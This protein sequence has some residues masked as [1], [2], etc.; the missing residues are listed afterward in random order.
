MR[1]FDENNQGG[2][3]PL[4]GANY[5]YEDYPSYETYEPQ[6]MQMQ[7]DQ[8]PYD[9][10]TNTYYD[11]GYVEGNAGPNPPEEK[12]KKRKWLFWLIFL[13]ALCVFIYSAYQLFIILKANWDE[14]REMERI[15]EIANIPENPETPFEVNWAELRNIN[16]DVV[17]WLIVP[18]TNISYPVVRGSNNSYYLERTFEKA[19]NY[20]GS[21]FMDY[22]NKGDFSDNNTFLY[23]H[24]TRHGTMFGQLENFVEQ[25][26]FAS[27]KYIYLFTPTQNYKAEIISFH[28]TKD[29]SDFYKYGIED[30]AEWEK[31]ID[32][33]TAND[34][35]GYVHSDVEVGASDRIVSLS[36]CSYEINNEL[37]DQRY[38]LH[39]KL[40]PWNGI[41]TTPVEDTQE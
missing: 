40:V 32:L 39:A 15:V 7:D 9:G 20:A 3:Q 6:D 41:Y 1:R 23:G 13:L 19:Y 28:S 10:H 34:I 37:T 12:K 4:Y 14:K 26:F 35:E 18:D 31:Y 2:Q 27:H 21:I 36:T 17:A 8:D 38:L 29:R 33:I 30:A 16:S 11:Q 5:D 25:D 22:N 24:N